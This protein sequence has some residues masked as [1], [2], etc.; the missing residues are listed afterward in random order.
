MDLFFTLAICTVLVHLAGRFLWF[1]SFRDFLPSSRYRKITLSFIGLAMLN[2][3]C[4]AYLFF[5]SSPPVVIYKGSLSLGWIPYVLLSFY[6]LPRLVPQQIFVLGMQGMWVFFLHTM[7][8]FTILYLFKENPIHE[9]LSLELTCYLIYFLVSFPLAARMFR[10]M[11]PSRQLINDKAYGYY[12]AMLP[13]LIVLIQMPISMDQDLWTMNKLISRLISL[14]CFIALYRYVSLQAEDIEN[15]TL[16]KSANEIQQKAIRFF[17]NNMLL[18]QASARQFSVLRHDMR[19]QINIVYG[20][21]S[22]KKYDEALHFLHTFN[23]HLEKTAI[24]PFCTNPYMNAVISVYIMKA[25]SAGIPVSCRVSFPDNVPEVQE[26]L[27]FALANL[28]ENAIRVQEKEDK[29]KRFL[30]LTLQTKGRQVVLSVENYCSIPLHFDKDGFPTT[31]EPGHGT[32]M[33]SVRHFITYYKGYKNFSQE[34]DTVRFEIYFT[35]PNEG[36]STASEHR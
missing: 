13:M 16:L 23:E 34:N 15:E 20:L 32:G 26:R 29:E 25:K 36:G 1:E 18:V 2:M 31:S 11:C 14:L 6:L 27:S 33:I 24:H 7:S 21:I 30:H 12:I 10:H 3:V 17:Q 22:E 8:I 19:H 5:V 4:Y 9:R 28:L 35:L